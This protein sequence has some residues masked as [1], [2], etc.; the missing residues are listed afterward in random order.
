[1]PLCSSSAKPSDSAAVFVGR[2][3]EIWP[4][5]EVLAKQ[6]RMSPLQL[7]QLVLNRWKGT[8]SP[9]ETQDIR[10]S[11]DLAKIER[12]YGYMQRVR[13]AVDEA[14]VGAKAREVFT[15]ASSCGY[16]FQ[17][18]RVYLV[19]SKRQ[20]D[21]YWAGACSRTDI[22]DSKEAVEDLKALR[23]WKGG[24]PLLP[25]IYGWISPSDFAPGVRVRVTQDKEGEWL[26]PGN[27]GYFSFDGLEK[28]RYR[29]QIQDGRGT[30]ERVID[31]QRTGCFE[32]SPWFKDTWR[33]AGV[34][35]LVPPVPESLR[36]PLN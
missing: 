13:F 31:L 20:Q 19:D 1:M 36:R 11:S 25:R 29:L 15:E 21:R 30:G 33:V 34:E 14:L 8:L 28:A 2:V 17:L 26:N 3:T 9:K 35:S 23:A 27:G 22:V 5:R 12:E 7:K 24:T 4:S 6:A 32:A 18:N 16:R 10:T